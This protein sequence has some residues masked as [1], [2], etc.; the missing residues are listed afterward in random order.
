MASYN[1]QDRLKEWT[2]A[3][4][5][6]VAAAAVIVP[7]FIPVTQWVH[8]WTDAQLVLGAALVLIPQTAGSEAIENDALSLLTAL[9]SKVPPDYA[10]AVQPLIAQLAR[11]TA[12]VPKFA[13]PVTAPTVMVPATRVP[14]PAPVPQV[15]N[16]LPEVTKPPKGPFPGQIPPVRPPHDLHIMPP[17]A[18]PEAT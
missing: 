1:L 15:A 10:A 6:M 12:G 8:Y 16:A 11:L 14:D 13:A 17:A 4:G 18:P 3:A 2:S 7:E 5:A 9:S